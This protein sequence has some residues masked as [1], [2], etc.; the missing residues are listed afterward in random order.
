MRRHPAAPAP[1]PQQ[2]HAKSKSQQHG[3]QGEAA[4]ADLGPG[5][6]P[7]GQGLDVRGRVPGGLGRLLL[8]HLQVSLRACLR[9]CVSVCA[10]LEGGNGRATYIHPTPDC[11][12]ITP[13]QPHHPLNTALSSAF[14]WRTCCGTCPRS[15]SPTARPG[16]TSR[17]RARYVNDCFCL[18]DSAR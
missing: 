17:S 12:E 4:R 18:G 2:K 1:P 10:W 15:A 7:A 6:R 5:A 13:K 8:L 11:L 9:L 16:T 14:C 3:D